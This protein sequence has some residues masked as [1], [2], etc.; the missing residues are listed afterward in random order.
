MNR[1]EYRRAL[2]RTKTIKWRDVIQELHQYMLKENRVFGKRQEIVELI[3]RR[4][5]ETRQSAGKVPGWGVYRGLLYPPKRADDSVDG[6]KVRQ[7]ALRYLLLFFDEKG[8]WLA[9]AKNGLLLNSMGRVI[10][11]G[12]GI[13]DYVVYDAFYWRSKSDSPGLAKI[14]FFND[15]KEAEV[16]YHYIT[17]KNGNE[18]RRLLGK[19]HKNGRNW[20]VDLIDAD[21]SDDMEPVRSFWSLLVSEDVNDRDYLMGVF[22]S[23]HRTERQPIAGKVL[24]CRNETNPDLTQSDYLEPPVAGSQE[25]RLR[26]IPNDVFYIM[27]NTRLSV[28]ADPIQSRAKLPYQ[29]EV[30]YLE[31]IAGTYQLY[32][33]WRTGDLNL[34]RVVIEKNGH[35]RL[36][37]GSDT[38]TGFVVYGDGVLIIRFSYDADAD[39]HRFYFML[40]IAADSQN[41][42]GVHAG[43]SDG[44]DILSGRIYLSRCET[45]RI[46]RITSSLPAYLAQLRHTDDK[47]HA[48][49][50]SPLPGSTDILWASHL[51]PPAATRKQ[52]PT[53]RVP[54][55][56]SKTYNVFFLTKTEFDPHRKIMDDRILLPEQPMQLVRLP[57]TIDGD[58]ATAFYGDREVTGSLAY[59][60]T[61][62][63][64]IRFQEPDWTTLLISVPGSG[65]QEARLHTYYFGVLTRMAEEPEASALI[66]IPESDPAY[67]TYECFGG[68]EDLLRM[69][70]RYRGLVSFLFGDWGRFIRMPGYHKYEQLLPTKY[71]TFR[72]V[73][74]AAACYY[75]GRGETTLCL[76]NLLRSHRHGFG[77]YRYADIDEGQADFPADLSQERD[78]LYDA[79]ATVFTNADIRAQVIA[80]WKLSEYPGDRFSHVSDAS[81]KPPG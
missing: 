27:S 33:P 45:P 25:R 18:Q 9:Y 69:E 22:A 74:F 53:T 78:M 20:Y 40:D 41:L 16:V 52:T 15:W 29:K 47:A 7:N 56:L 72:R 2:E 63:L 1:D 60:G 42:T 31:T 46:D 19:V 14:R 73:F 80:L 65:T 6:T 70:Q 61:E 36:N 24:L 54:A 32:Q 38:I 23:S 77:W 43:L 26:N 64:T 3:E 5:E 8:V 17:V 67:L 21:P 79:L 81:E 58:Q 11:K 71:P 51:T 75:A 10:P 68:L 13:D 34:A 59:D 55:Y 35:V 57:L 12:P 37:S 49:L 66:L 30:A 50:T 62:G 76:D 44:R 28:V 48:Y 4:H 39:Y